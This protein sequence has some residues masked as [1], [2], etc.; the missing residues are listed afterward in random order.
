[1]SLKPPKQFSFRAE[2]R[3]EW[4]EEFVRFRNVSKLSQE[5]GVTQRDT[6]LYVMGPEFEKIYQ[7]QTFSERT[8]GE[9][10]DARQEMEFDTD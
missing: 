6:L 10:A 3:P 8:V 5:D 9:E 7:N 2:E 1:M 4:V